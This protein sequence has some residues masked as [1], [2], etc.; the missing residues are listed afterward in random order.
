MCIRC[1]C[2]MRSIFNTLESLTLNDNTNTHLFPD[3]N[4]TYKLF[5]KFVKVLFYTFAQ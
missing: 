5:Y 4:L 2:Y 3:L 1:N